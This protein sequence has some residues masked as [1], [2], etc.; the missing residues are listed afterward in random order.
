MEYLQIEYIITLDDIVRF[1]NLVAKKKNEKGCLVW[2][3][4]YNE[5]GYGKFGMNRKLYKAHRIAYY[6][7][8]KI[9]PKGLDVA[10][11]CNNPSCCN[12]EHL[13]LATGKQN[14]QDAHNDGLC[15]DGENHPYAKLSDKEINL[16]KE[17][18]RKGVSMQEI[19]SKFGV[20]QPSISN[21][22]AGRRRKQKK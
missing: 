9:D 3:G 4:S 16:V 5:R 17:E 6:I 12:Y 14:T 2:L 15:K 21:I 1:Q 19:A 18:Q 22:C 8:Y 11:K 10:H 20:S 7:H 13:Y